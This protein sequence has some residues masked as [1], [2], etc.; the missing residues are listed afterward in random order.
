MPR[1]TTEENERMLGRLRVELEAHDD[2]KWYFPCNQCR[3]LN[4]RILVRKKI[5]RHC[6]RHGNC[7]GEVYISPHGK[8]VIIYF[9]VLIFLL[10]FLLF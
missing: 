5:E 2:G 1:I 8:L 6:W 7:K 4:R 10:N 3:G 9:F